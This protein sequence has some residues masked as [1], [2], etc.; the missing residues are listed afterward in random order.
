MADL[1]LHNGDGKSRI[2]APK[3]DQVLRANFLQL[4]E[5]EQ[6][7]QETGLPFDQAAMKWIEAN[8]EYWRKK[9]N[10]M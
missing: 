10:Q 5:M 8:S 9:H 2:V 4:K 1:I 7:A 3:E 6:Y